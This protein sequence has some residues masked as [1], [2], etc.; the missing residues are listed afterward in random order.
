MKSYSG[1][2]SHKNQVDL[3]NDGAIYVH[4]SRTDVVFWTSIG[5]MKLDTLQNRQLTLSRGILGSLG[6]FQSSLC[7]PRYATKSYSFAQGVI[8]C[9]V[10]ET[11]IQSAVM[12]QPHV[13]K[14]LCCFFLNCFATVQISVP[15]RTH[16]C[17]DMGL[18]AA[19]VFL[20]FMLVTLCFHTGSG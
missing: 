13:L 9:A 7:S 11:R 15:T 1:Q 8:K 12:C 19:V 10:C 2:F 17:A 4:N 18:T 16:V 20:K 14:A 5:A 6:I 3:E